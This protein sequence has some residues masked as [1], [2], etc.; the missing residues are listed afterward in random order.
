MQQFVDLDWFIVRRGLVS[1]ESLQYRACACE[2]DCVGWFQAVVFSL[3]HPA[4][5]ENIFDNILS[6]ARRQLSLLG[7]R[8]RGA[9][10]RIFFNWRISISSLVLAFVEYRVY[11][12]SE[13]WLDQS[14]LFI[15]REFNISPF[16]TIDVRSH[17]W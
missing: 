9:S 4:S 12:F 5:A 16:T 13:P 8:V 11:F 15:G 14:A 2:L 17:V 1:W 7:D 6:C 10:S 3:W